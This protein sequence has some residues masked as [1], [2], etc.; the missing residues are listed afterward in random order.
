MSPFPALCDGNDERNYQVLGKFN[1]Q[2]NIF[3]TRLKHLGVYLGKNNL[4]LNSPDCTKL[5]WRWS[6]TLNVKDKTI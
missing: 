1:G 2:R 3:S 6:M 4:D 5:N